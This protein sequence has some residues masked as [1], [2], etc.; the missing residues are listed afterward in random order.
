MISEATPNDFNLNL[1]A[2]PISVKG[3][4]LIIVQLYKIICF[5]MGMEE[6]QLS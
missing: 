4:R 6:A 5:S 3:S 2:K 1:R